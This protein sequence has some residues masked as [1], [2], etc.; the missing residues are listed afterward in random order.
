MARTTLSIRYWLLTAFILI[1]VAGFGAC[2]SYKKDPVDY[3]NPNIGGIGYLRV[4]TA[5]TVL[6]PHGMMRLAPITTPGI[7]DRYLADKIYG[8][9]AGGVVL[10]P[11][12][13]VATADPTAY[14]SHYDHGSETASPHYY[15]VSL[16]DSA[17]DVEYTVSQHAAH[18]QIAFPDG[19]PAH[20]L[21]TVGSNGEL[22]QPS[23]NAVAGREAAAPGCRYFYAEISK[24]ARSTKRFEGIR[25]PASG[26]QQA[27]S[28]GLGLVADF[29]VAKEEHVGLRIGTSFVSV[30]QARKNLLAEMPDWNF[31]AHRQRAREAWNRALD[32]IAVKG[33]T[34]DERTIFY[35][36]LYRTLSRGADITE[37]G[38]YYSAYDRQ[39]H[40]AYDR[41]FYTDDAFW[42]TY[43]SVH[44]VQLLLEPKVQEDMAQSLALM[45]Q[46]S[47]WMPN[48]PSTRGGQR[49]M[50]GHHATAFITD[51]Y[52][53][54]YQDFDVE[55]AYAG[56][57][58]NAM[59]STMLRSRSGPATP[60]DR[61]YM[62]KG[63]FPALG[64]NEKETVAEVH[65]FEKRQAVS[66]TLENAYDDWCLAQMA[67]TL[68]KQADYEYFLKRAL[69][70]RN[71]FDSRIGFMAPKT[72]DGK[73]VYDAPEFNPIW[74]GGQGG[75]DYYTEMNAWIYT[76]HV[77]HDV[78]GLMDLMGGR[79]RLAAKLDTLFTEQYG[80]YPYQDK[81]TTP[82][83]KY[84]FL[85]WF[86]DQ[87]GLVGQ[88][89]IGN[90]PAFH[91][92][93]LYNY[94]G[95][96]WK[97]QRRTRELMKIWYDAGPRGI[98][99]DEDGGG[100]SS[101]YVM[102]AM[103][104]FTVCPGRPVYDIGSPIFEEVRL[105]LGNGKAFTITAKRVSEKNKYIQS[106]ELNGKPLNRPW[107]TH[108]DIVNG[109]SLTLEMGPRPNK[110]W[111]SAPD[112]APPSMSR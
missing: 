83:T 40:L 3:V 68:N 16:E 50:I 78:A 48:T 61:V 106:A 32:R 57:K 52:M 60:L 27:E 95:E 15:S 65:P 82:G 92:P 76:F 96:P 91:I 14:A 73:W 17:V 88:Y 58:K 104:L 97:T 90:E 18:F 35:T 36:A 105:T 45:Y 72:A 100:M 98:V 75:R 86:P 81:G 51:T 101:W 39:V 29:D 26:R 94:V 89:A 112:A 19:A 46:Q 6:L 47:G 54:G 102:S 71:V 12:S 1:G 84:F 80:N 44:P 13:G 4:A 109:G 67:K 79:E 9:P 99:G 70:Y 66:I 10:M 108:G 74:A 103:G 107:F 64:K 41:R 34:E 2:G 23:P 49:G 87:A 111:G 42:D 63:F 37:G 59:E 28:E 20:V 25:I 38:Q 22:V 85:S 53:K 24:P 77:Q 8:F 62:E 5:P 30:D 31:N 43:R 7:L 33:G 11:L 69:N 21:F 55:L 56:M 110:A 93:Y